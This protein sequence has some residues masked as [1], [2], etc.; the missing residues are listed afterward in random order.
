MLAPGTC[1]FQGC[2]PAPG[3]AAAG[4]SACRCSAYIWWH[5]A[6]FARQKWSLPTHPSAPE[7]LEPKI[8]FP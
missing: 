1:S 7:L 8:R 3:F 5:K 4:P 2:E 6:F